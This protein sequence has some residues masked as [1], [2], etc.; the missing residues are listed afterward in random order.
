MSWSF[1]IPANVG[2]KLQCGIMLRSLVYIFFSVVNYH[3]TYAYGLRL[4]TNLVCVM[5]VLLSY[6]KLYM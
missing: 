3:V 4:M 6:L 5:N 2:I 1:S